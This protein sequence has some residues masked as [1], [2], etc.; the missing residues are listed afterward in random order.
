MH[1]YE[2]LFYNQFVGGLEGASRRYVTDYWVNIMPEAVNDL[3]A[4]L[5]HDGHPAGAQTLIRSRFAAS[6]YPSRIER[7]QI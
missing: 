7:T 3:E 4:F 1:P 5:R 6:D 2:Y